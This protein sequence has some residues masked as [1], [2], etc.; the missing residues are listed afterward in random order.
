MLVGGRRPRSPPLAPRP[1][2]L[3]PSPLAPVVELVL[4]VEAALGQLHGHV[5]A[6]PRPRG[7]AVRKAAHGAH[8]LGRAKH[9]RL[10]QKD[11]AGEGQ[12][13]STDQPTERGCPGARYA[14][15]AAS[16]PLT[17]REGDAE[18][19]Q[20]A[21]DPGGVGL[22]G[23][24]AQQALLQAL[25]EVEQRALLP[26]VRPH[27]AQQLLHLQLQQRGLGLGRVLHAGGIARPLQPG[28]LRVAAAIGLAAA[29]STASSAVLALAF[30]EPAVALHAD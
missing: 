29:G 19:G 12:A 18:V 20:E 26:R 16:P 27:L 10:L 2:P 9:K 8:A 13:L 23:V 1:S 14:R 3:A 24:Q 28:A 4:G 6:H 25:Q 17:H 11:G 7:A 21:L 22:G 15:C 5:H 30:S